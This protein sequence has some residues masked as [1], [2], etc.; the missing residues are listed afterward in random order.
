M[1]QLFSDESTWTLI[2]GEI[3]II[4]QKMRK[5]EAWECALQGKSGSKIDSF[6][7]EEV[8]KKL[9]IERFQEEVIT[10]YHVGCQ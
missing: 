5:A 4:L 7:K 3:Q 10:N 9:L 6:T 2:D 8:K 1:V